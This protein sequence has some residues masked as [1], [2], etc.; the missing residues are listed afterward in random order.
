MKIRILFIA[1]FFPFTWGL[2]QNVDSLVHL[3]SKNHLHDSTKYKV[4]LDL[5]RELIYVKPDQALIFAQKMELY[6]KTLG[7]YVKEAKANSLMGYALEILNDYDKAEEKYFRMLEIGRANQDPGEIGNAYNNLGIIEKTRGNY[8][9][10]IEYQLKGAET[11]K[12]AGNKKREAYCYGNIGVVFQRLGD[13]EKALKNFEICL[14]IDEKEGNTRGIGISLNN[15]AN[16]Y[17]FMG[18]YEK[19]LKLWYKTLEIDQSLGNKVGESSTKRNIGLAYH[20]LGDREKAMEF[21]VKSLAQ[22]RELNQPRSVA[23]SLNNIGILLRES[24]DH[25]KALAYQLEALELRRQVNA[26]RGMA[27]S[28]VNIA[29]IYLDLKNTEK[30][31]PYLIKGLELRMEMGNTD[32]IA[33][34]YIGI[35]EYYRQ[36]EEPDSVIKYLTQ[37]FKLSSA[38]KLAVEKRKSLQE[39]YL[40]LYN[41]NKEKEAEKYLDLL[42][43]ARMDDIQT[44]LL[45]LAEQKKELYLAKMQLDFDLYYDHVLRQSKEQT[46]NIGKAYNLALLIKGLLLKSSTAMRR[47]IHKSEDETLIKQ[48]EDWLY[49]KRKI[50]DLYSVGQDAKAIEQKADSLEKVLIRKSKVVSDYS[51]LK[52]FDW[53]FVRNGLK[54][55]EFAV[56]FIRFKNIENKEYT[57]AAFVLSKDLPSPLMIEICLE[58]DLEKILGT[59][60]GNNLNYIENLYGNKGDYKTELYNL[61]WKPIEKSIKNAKTV[62]VSPAGLLHKVAFHSLSKNSKVLLSH[63]LKFQIKSSTAEIDF[64]EDSELKIKNAV[65]FGGIEYSQ[66]ENAPSLWKYLEGTLSEVKQID[67]KLKAYQIDSK[68]VLAGEATEK[69]FKEMI[70]GKQLIHIATHGFFYPDPEEL[71]NYEEEQISLVDSI[72]FR[73][74]K[75]DRSAYYSITKNGNPLMRSGLVFANADQAYSEEKNSENDGL[76]TAQE[77]LSIDLND[78]KLIVLSACETGLGDI[79]GSEGVYGLQRSFKMAGVKRLIFSLW[80]VPDKETAEFMNL[81]YQNLMELKSIEKAFT[82][83][84]SF[85]SK[86]YDPYFWAAFVLI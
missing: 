2:S 18:N 71:K 62:Y 48:Y 55:G 63:N 74:G 73:S 1:L 13:H 59:Y 38:N 83:A 6:S 56:E 22:K 32:G 29:A 61:I 50:A 33:N 4:S 51:K 21:Y 24:G 76:L 66:N 14:A 23:K 40:E 43:Q 45:V 17:H 36:K 37:A 84:Q 20:D 10:A 16:V 5:V 7:D 12:K 60:P 54:K 9:K 78:T 82:K 72:I 25:E 27:E 19:A 65:L 42:M 67:Q 81:F 28:N 80:Q 57:Y 85:M 3:L 34:S 52:S 8:K 77:L 44:N 64:V 86:K 75:E 15:M 70:A 68:L 69:Q 39:L 47:S 31:W 53:K 46:K 49:L 30:A 26:K 79:R 41:Q 11:F 58:K 35:S